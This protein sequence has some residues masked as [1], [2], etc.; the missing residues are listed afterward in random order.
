L[1]V[2]NGVADADVHRF[3]HLA[4]FIGFNCKCE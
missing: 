3:N 2:G 1:F 4:C